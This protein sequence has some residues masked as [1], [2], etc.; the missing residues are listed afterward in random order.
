MVIRE[1]QVNQVSLVS[2][3]SQERMVPPV[4]LVEL[5]IQVNQEHQVCLVKR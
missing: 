3:D 4:N 2:E 5:E 1:N